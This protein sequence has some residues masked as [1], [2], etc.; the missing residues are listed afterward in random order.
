MAGIGFELKKLFGKDDGFSKTIK[1]YVFSILVS[2]GPWIITIITLNSFIL[3]AGMYFKDIFERELFMGAIVYSFV[4]SQLLTA[5][6]QF[7]IVRYISDKIYEKDYVSIRASYDGLSKII[8]VMMSAFCLLY[9]WGRPLP[10]YF[11]FSASAVVVMI[12]LVWIL[13]VYLSAIKN[14]ANISYGY[15]ISSLVSVGLAMLF[16][17]HPI[18]FPAYQDSTNL[19]LAYLGGVVVLYAVLLYSFTSAFKET[20]YKDFEF[21]SYFKK[22]PG[23]FFMGFF[24]TAGLWVDDVIIW[25]SNLGVTVHSTF[26]FAPIYD[27]AIFFAYLTIIPTMVLFMVSLETRFYSVYKKTYAYIT[28]NGTYEQIM[29]SK[30]NMVRVIF[31]Q[32]T[33]VMEIQLIITLT[34]IVLSKKLFAYLGMPLLLGEIFKIAALGALCNGMVLVIML[35]LLYFDARKQSLIISILFFVGNAMGTAY[36]LPKGVDYFGFGY[37]LGSLVTLLVSIVIVTVYLKDLIFDTFF[38]QPLFQKEDKGWWFKTFQALDKISE[39]KRNSPLFQSRQYRLFAGS[40]VLLVGTLFF[41]FRES[42]PRLTRESY[43]K[44]MIIGERS[45]EKNI[46]ADHNRVVVDEMPL[47]HS[48]SRS[49]VVSH[50]IN[51]IQSA[52]LYVQSSPVLTLYRHQSIS[53]KMAFPSQRVHTISNRINRLLDDGLLKPLLYEKIGDQHVWLSGTSWVF[54]VTDADAKDHDQ[55]IESL[56]N[57]WASTLIDAFKLKN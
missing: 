34:F 48:D 20:N 38:K 41:G 5:P 7:L 43:L 44:K 30:H 17:N 55:S 12:S 19:L 42:S 46:Q 53:G 23:L 27:N 40:L 14:F 57:R 15:I 3:L 6:W 31:N 47:I 8:I 50:M 32:L 56:G 33:K 26:R 9:Y 36:F 51:G 18:P 2:V 10:L 21:L 22:I 16:M 54:T 13:M 35:V 24:Y 37:F 52:T 45:N 4:F 29:T 39:K 11:V 49:V 28:H 25:F 1:A